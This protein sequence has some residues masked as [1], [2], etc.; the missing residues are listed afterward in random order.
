MLVD[1]GRMQNRTMFYKTL[2]KLFIYSIL[3]L[4]MFEAE[5]RT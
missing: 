1:G 3:E 4:I 5:I 2:G